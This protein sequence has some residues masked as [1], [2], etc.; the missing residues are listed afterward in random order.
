MDSLNFEQL[1]TAAAH[2]VAIALNAQ[3]AH[4]DHGATTEAFK[5]QKFI[6]GGPRELYDVSLT[7][8]AGGFQVGQVA[9]A[10]QQQ[11]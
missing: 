5:V 2:G 7:L 9:K 10:Q 4:A 11:L 3:R 6:F 1:A 8:G